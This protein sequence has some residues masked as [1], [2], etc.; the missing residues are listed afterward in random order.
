[1]IIQLQSIGIKNS[2]KTKKNYFFIFFFHH[3]IVL[4]IPSS[5]FVFGDQDRSFFALEQF[6][7]KL[8][9]IDGF[10]LLNLILISLPDIFIIFS[11]SSFTVT[12]FPDPQLYI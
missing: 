10:D 8:K 6:K 12:G 4:F 2:I 5:I 7:Y 11:H 9:G 3:V 1:M